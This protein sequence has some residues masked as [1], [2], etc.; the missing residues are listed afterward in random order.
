MI[1]KRYYWRELTEDGLLKLVKSPYTHSTVG[2]YGYDT[3]EEAIRD[4]DV[5]FK[6]MYKSTDYMLVKLY[7][8]DGSEE[9]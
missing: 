9:E 5:I 2:K 4:F 7:G 6:G 3:E 8:I 1:T